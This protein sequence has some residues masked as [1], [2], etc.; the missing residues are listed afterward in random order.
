[1]RGMGLYLLKGFAFFDMQDNCTHYAPTSATQLG[2]HTMKKPLK[3]ASCLTVGSFCRLGFESPVGKRV[4]QSADSL[5][6]FSTVGESR[7]L[8]GLS[9]SKPKRN[10]GT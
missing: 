6:T 4:L 5:P 7:S 8:N 3:T 2:I 10:V 9:E 1:M